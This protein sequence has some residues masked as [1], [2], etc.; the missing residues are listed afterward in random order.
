MITQLTSALIDFQTVGTYPSPICS[1]FTSRPTSYNQVMWE[2][3]D[4]LHK[5]LNPFIFVNSS[6]KAFSIYPRQR[7]F[8]CMSL[9]WLL[10][11]WSRSCA[12]SRLLTRWCRSLL[13]SCSTSLTPSFDH[14]NKIQE[15]LCFISS[16]HK[17]DNFN[18][19]IQQKK[20]ET[21]FFILSSFTN[22][23]INE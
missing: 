9:S 13:P 2:N 12:R 11:S 3:V 5:I 15:R 7:S 4:M 17:I 6:Y 18:M 22:K 10:R 19:A 16:L 1:F 8:L 23:Y 21:Y 14:Q 20:S